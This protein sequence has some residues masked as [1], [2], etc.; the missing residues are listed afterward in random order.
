MSYKVAKAIYDLSGPDA[1][2][3]VFQFRFPN[4]DLY[5][6]SDGWLENSQ[7][8]CKAKG[9]K[10]DLIVTWFDM[11]QIEQMYVSR[12]ESLSLAGEVSKIAHILQPF[13]FLGWFEKH[14]PLY[15]HLFYP[16][17]CE[18]AGRVFNE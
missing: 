12:I 14:S 6:L 13:E 15:D 18:M 1:L 8:I 2:L 9:S 16:H 5:S 11:D 3:N 17:Q 4:L 7:Y 10:G